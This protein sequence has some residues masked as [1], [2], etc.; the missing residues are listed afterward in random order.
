MS[1]T[2]VSCEPT[3]SAGERLQTYASDR[4]ATGTGMQYDLR[5]IIN[6]QYVSIA[7]AIILSVALT[8]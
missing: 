2:P 7:F 1:M 3:V 4:A 5:Y 8:L 6:Y